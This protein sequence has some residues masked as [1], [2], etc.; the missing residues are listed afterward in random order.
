MAKIGVTCTSRDVGTTAWSAADI[1]LALERENIESRPVWKPMHRQPVFRD[2]R[3]RGGAVSESLFRDC[4]CL[5]SGSS[6]TEADLTRVVECIRRVS[7]ST[8]RR[9]A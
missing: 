2:C 3:V 6:L 1:R 5:P 8:C 4:L 7:M 9:A